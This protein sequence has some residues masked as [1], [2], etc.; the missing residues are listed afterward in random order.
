[1]VHTSALRAR[2]Q[3]TLAC[4]G[5]LLLWWRLGNGFG[6]ALFALT[7][8]LAVVA[9]FAPARYAPVQRCL[10]HLTHWLVTGVSWLLLGLVY[11]GIFAPL[12][13][14]RGFSRRDPLQLRPKPD[15]ST[16]FRPLPPA[17]PDHFKRQF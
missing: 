2:L 3:A 14:F 15:A 7:A 9:W 11:F 8:V 1:M 10:D 16:Y 4:L 5:A 17:V 12:R 13:A 6:V